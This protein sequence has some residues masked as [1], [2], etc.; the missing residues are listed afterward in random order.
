MDMHQKV[1][2]FA[3]SLDIK[4]IKNNRLILLTPSGLLSGLPV[5]SDEEAVQAKLLY[6]FLKSAEKAHNKDY[7]P[8][9]ERHMLFDDNS[10]LLKDVQLITST[11]TN[12]LG[13][14]I[15]DTSSIVAVSIG[16]YQKPF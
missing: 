9:E 8:R 4:E 11:A 16:T 12:S 5:Y 1:I 6:K 10:I 3:L 7:V 2:S 13:A 15:L 14:L